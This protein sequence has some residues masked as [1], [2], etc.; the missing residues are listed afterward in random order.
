LLR[1]S[2]GGNSKTT[3]ITC[4]TPSIV[5][6]KET[7]S[8]LLFA[9]RAKQIK[10]KATLNVVKEYNT[11]EHLQQVK[12]LEEEVKKLK[13]DLAKFHDNDNLNAYSQINFNQ[14]CT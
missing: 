12:L 10:T 5:N 3:I 13:L 7:L 2:L 14:E 1:D 11:E 9:D 4:I 8:S 6:V